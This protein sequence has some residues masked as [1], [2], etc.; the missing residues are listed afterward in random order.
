MI[1]EAGYP[2]DEDSPH[3]HDEELRPGDVRNEKAFPDLGRVLT[4]IRPGDRLGLGDFGMLGASAVWAW[5]AKILV[6]KGIAV[7]DCTTRFVLDFSQ[8]GALEA[9]YAMAI[10]RRDGAKAAAVLQAGSKGRPRKTKAAVT[11]QI[12]RER[13]AGDTIPAIAK[14]HG[15]SVQ[16][17]YRRLK[18]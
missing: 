6:K 17:V 8:P 18:D 4:G 5:A 9:G 13:A 7:E 3:F 2:T 16:T 1:R 12:K 10:A 14:R 11:A 15:I